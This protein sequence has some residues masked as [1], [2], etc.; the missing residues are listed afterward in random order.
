MLRRPSAPQWISKR[1]NIFGTFQIECEKFW[2][3]WNFWF[4]MKKSWKSWKIMKKSWK[5][6][7]IMKIMKIM[8]KSKN[9]EKFSKKSEKSWKIEIFQKVQNFSH[10]I[11]KVLKMFCHLEIHWGALGRRNID[12]EAP[13]R[14]KTHFIYNLLKLTCNFKIL[15]TCRWHQTEWDQGRIRNS[16][17]PE[18]AIIWAPEVRKSI[19]R[20]IMKKIAPAAPSRFR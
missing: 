3:F 8:K 9:F 18:G 15:L 1:Q 16:N 4:F 12:R 20:Y 14:K 10:S 13:P 6:W 11:W 2:T 17:R 19:I 5:S 7:K